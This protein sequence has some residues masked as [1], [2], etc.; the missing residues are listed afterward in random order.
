[1]AKKQKTN[2][3]FVKS[4]MEMGT[5]LN[6]VFVVQAVLDNA[7]EVLVQFS[8]EEAR[9]HDKTN[10]S[11]VSMSIW[12]ATALQIIEEYDKEYCSNTLAEV[13]KERQKRAAAVEAGS[14]YHPE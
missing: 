9:E 4:V 13:E 12:R 10:P 7:K 14:G 11:M 2:V 8:A 3:Q 5:P 6:Q 1:M